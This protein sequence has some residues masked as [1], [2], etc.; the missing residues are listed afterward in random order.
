[1]HLAD[2]LRLRRPWGDR[3]PD[4]LGEIRA[5]RVWL[6][7][8]DEAGEP[9]L[10]SFYA[11]VAWPPGAILRAECRR[12]R[13]EMF[14]TMGSP[15][16][17]EPAPG[18][19]CVC[20]IYGVAD[21]TAADVQQYVQHPSWSHIGTTRRLEKPEGLVAVLGRVALWGRVRVGAAGWRAEYAR[22]LGLV[23]SPQHAEL[24]RLVAQRYEVPIIP[25]EEVRA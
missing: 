4:V 23:V 22:P 19:R 24:I 8:P 21:P 9:A 13:D 2:W 20:G 7:H 3:A 15:H 10:W 17:G 16:E 5:W 14:R 12:D 11:R 6:I 1:M 18:A 25:S